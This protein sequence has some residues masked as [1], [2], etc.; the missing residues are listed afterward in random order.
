MNLNRW[1]LE[2]LAKLAVGNNHDDVTIGGQTAT[3]LP[4]EPTNTV[5]GGVLALAS[6]SGIYAR[7]TFTL[8]PDLHVDLAY[9]WTDH[10]RTYV[11]YSIL[12]WGDVTRAG[13]QIDLNVDP[14]NLPPVSP[15]GLPFPAYVGQRTDFWAHGLN[16]ERSSDSRDAPRGKVQL[17][18]SVRRM[19]KEL[20]HH[21]SRMRTCVLQ[22]VICGRLPNDLRGP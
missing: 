10:W 1:S 16:V 17:R 15:G 13:E 3:T 7:D 4:G 12:Y 22:A 18:R 8:I 9:Q 19:V 21:S 2:I 20:G 6:N 11:G 14:R 5:N